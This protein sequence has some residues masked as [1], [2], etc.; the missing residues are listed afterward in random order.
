LLVARHCYGELPEIV[1]AVHSRAPGVD[2]FSIN[3]LILSENARGTDAMVPWPEAAPAINAATTMMRQ[4]GYDVAFWPVP[5][6]VFRGDNAKFVAAEVRRA[7]RRPSARPNLRYLDPVVAAGKTTG[8]SS[9]AELARPRVCDSCR[10]Q[11]IC[12]GVEDWY[13]ERFGAAGLGLERP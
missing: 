8:R 2:R 13:Y 6:C 4:H 5:L 1:R 7:V 11:P 3:R 10:Y 12:G 9:C